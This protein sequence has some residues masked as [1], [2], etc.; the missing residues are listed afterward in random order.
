MKIRVPFLMQCYLLNFALVL[1]LWV[2][3]A[4]AAVGAWVCDSWGSCYCPSQ[5]VYPDRCHDSSGRSYECGYPKCEGI[6]EFSAIGMVLVIS[7]I[8]IYFLY[9]Y[10]LRSSK[11][12]PRAQG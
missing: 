1:T 7:G 4:D 3:G 10:R 9:R 5:L 11:Q 12:T 2:L 6:P 8:G